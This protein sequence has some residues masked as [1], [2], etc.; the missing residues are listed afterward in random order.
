MKDRPIIILE[1]LLE[2]QACGLNAR[3]CRA[4]AKVY[5]RWIHQLEVKAK[6]LDRINPPGMPRRL[7]RLSP[8]LQ[9]L[10]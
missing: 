1:P 10:N 8:R 2:I 9:R 7:A 3:Q 6:I 4:L 5:A